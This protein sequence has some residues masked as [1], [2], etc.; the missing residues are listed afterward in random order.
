MKQT[1]ALPQR[2]ETRLGACI[3]HWVK[4]EPFAERSRF[5][6]AQ[7]HRAKNDAVDAKMLPSWDRFYIRTGCEVENTG[8]DFT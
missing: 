1:G 7:G 3:C 6:K 8:H 4:S 5:R 2:A